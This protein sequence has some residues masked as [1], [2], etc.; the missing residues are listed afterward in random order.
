MFPMATPS[1]H[2]GYLHSKPVCDDIV[3]VILLSTKKLT[4]VRAQ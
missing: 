4:A 1:F 2:R 3:M